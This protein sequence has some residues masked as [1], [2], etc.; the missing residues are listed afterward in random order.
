MI[1]GMT[2]TPKDDV[3]IIIISDGTGETA[4]LMTKAAVVQFSDREIQYTPYKKIRTQVQIATKFEAAPQRTDLIVY[5][6]LPPQT[7]NATKRLTP[8]NVDRACG[9]L[10]DPRD[11]CHEEVA[12]DFPE[13]LNA[14]GAEAGLRK[15]SLLFS[16]AFS[17]PGQSAEAPLADCARMVSQR[18]ERKGQVECRLCTPRGKRAARVQRS[19]ATPENAF[20]LE[21]AR[22]DLWRNAE[23]GE[24]G[25]VER[26][27]KLEGREG[28]IF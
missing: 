12:C 21:A 5:K 20:V 11:W 15:E 23:I 22:G 9:A 7:R 18:M 26:A 4:S 24:K 10:A 17:R 8:K 1:L 6:L 2:D 19:K 14:I 16:Y 13:W 28:S 3:K 27:E 25:D